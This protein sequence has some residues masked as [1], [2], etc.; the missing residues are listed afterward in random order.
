MHHA[1]IELPSEA[2]VLRIVLRLVHL[3]T[4]EGADG[5]EVRP[6]GD[7]GEMRTIHRQAAQEGKANEARCSLIVRDGHLG[8]EGAVGLK[9]GRARATMPDACDHPGKLMQA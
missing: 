5:L 2:L 9:V 1:L 4:G 8:K 7:Q 3:G 6:V